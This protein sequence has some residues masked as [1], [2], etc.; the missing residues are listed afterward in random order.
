MITIIQKNFYFVRILW[1]NMRRA[2]GVVVCGRYPAA[3]AAKQRTAHAAPRPQTGF[4]GF[5][6]AVAY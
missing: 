1:Y 6:A 2:N 5:I 4:A 3:T